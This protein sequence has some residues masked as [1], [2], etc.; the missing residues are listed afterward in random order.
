MNL[1]PFIPFATDV[2]PLALAAAGVGVVMAVGLS[3]LS[4]P[5]ISRR[6]MPSPQETTLADHIPFHAVDDDGSTVHLKNGH[7][8]QYFLLAT[9]DLSLATDGQFRAEHGSRVSMLDS[10]AAQGLIL[11]LTTLRVET[12]AQAPNDHS[13]IVAKSIARDWN[14]QFSSYHRS[15]NVLCVE[16]KDLKKLNEARVALSVLGTKGAERLDQSGSNAIGLTLGSYLGRIVSPCGRP[17]PKGTGPNFD[18]ALTSDTL[19]FRPD[20]IAEF[21]CGSRKKFGIAVGVKMIGATFKSS[22]ADFIDGFPGDLVVSRTMRPYTK[23]AALIRI[24]F[25]RNLARTQSDG[26]EDYNTA[27]HAAMAQSVVDGIGEEEHSLFEY[28]ETIFIY[29]DSIEECVDKEARIMRAMI[30]EGLTPAREKGATEAAWF[31]QFPTHNDFPRPYDLFSPAISMHFALKRPNE[32]LSNSDWGDGPL[33]LFR[34]ASGNPY[35]FQFHQSEEKAALGHVLII[36]PTGSGKTLIAEF[37]A[38]MAS[39]HKNVKSFF[40]DRFRGT[41]IY[42]LAMGGEYVSLNAEPLPWSNAGGLN[43]FDCE[44]RNT[45]RAFLSSWLEGLAAIDEHDTVSQKEISNAVDIAFELPREHRSLRAIYNVAF[46]PNGLVKNK[47]EAFAIGKDSEFFNAEKDAIDIDNNHLV[48][49]DMT[50][51]GQNKRL[52]GATIEYLMQRIKTSITETDSKGFIFID[53]TEPMIKAERPGDPEPRM[54][55]FLRIFL[56]ESRKIGCVTATVFQR[57][58]ALDDLP[59]GQALRTQ[60]ATW[61]LF[62]NPAAQPQDYKNYS[63]NERELAFVMGT[64]KL[65]KSMPRS[66]LIKRPNTGESVVLDIDMSGLGPKL[67]L[68][69]SSAEDLSTVKRLFNMHGEKWIEEYIDESL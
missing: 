47:L 1:E 12:S 8:A 21:T 20:G 65:A 38:L 40:F 61:F 66:V 19:W 54:A 60:V 30:D 5:V 28:C 29:E 59:L 7:V 63:L 15:V 56:Q 25:K 41:A 46:T 16:A 13:N 2:S 42:N 37:L 58:D 34:T 55:K 51:M 48:S 26:K 53:E 62:Q 22:M 43:P 4:I 23:E 49:F 11:R 36:A 9:Q 10:L 69:S 64:S 33:A 67:K 52:E 32:G 57:P 50:D 24:K 6:V 17:A 31:S 14:K 3:A 27:E 39:R 45:Q 35:K 44:G 68:L 18:G